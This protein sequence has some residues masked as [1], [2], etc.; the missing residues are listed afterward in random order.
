LDTF[1]TA[2]RAFRYSDEYMEKY[3]GAEIWI[4]HSN[5]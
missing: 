1:N 2:K 3:P 5:K 4:Y